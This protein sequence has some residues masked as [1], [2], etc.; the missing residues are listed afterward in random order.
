MLIREVAAGGDGL[1]LV[2][3]CTLGQ[4]CHQAFQDKSEVV[5]LK[6]TELLQVAVGITEGGI[7]PR[8]C[9]HNSVNS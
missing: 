5:P 3:T 7:W 6:S 4:F 2:Q 1:G 8:V 9:S